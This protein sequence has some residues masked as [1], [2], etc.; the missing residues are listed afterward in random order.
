[1][2]K[3]V[4][5]IM[6][7]GIG[8]RYGGGI[9]QLAKVGPAGEIIMDYS[10]YDA[11]RAGFEKV[12]FVIRRDIEKDFKEIIGDRISREMEVAY[13]YQDADD[14]PAPF[15]RPAGRT[16][17]WGTGH[18]ILACRELIDA[19]F[20]VINADDYYGYEAFR[21]IYQFLENVPETGE[22]HYHF[23]MAGF[24][25]GNTLSD[26]GTVT[27][28]ICQVSAD[29]G[30]MG[31]QETKEIAKNADGTIRGV[32]AG[33]PC[34][35]WEDDLVSMNFWG[36][37][38]DFIGELQKRFVAF[39]ENIPEGDLKAE[40]L[41][42]IIVDDMLKEGVATVDVLPTNDSWF[43]LTYA[44]DRDSVAGRLKELAEDGTYPNPLFP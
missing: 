26:N 33:K 31:V 40:Y 43:G 2:K 19:P 16:K 34:S 24:V 32:Y 28:G 8:S 44:E 5:V 18:A 7:A 9:K 3:P 14:L 12:I 4:L 10:I 38:P 30:L 22:G 15:T 39:L 42:P 37:T 35:P 36:Y 23:A 6:A 13:A 29:G 27:R 11:K 41:L 21:K 1:M 17:P 25:L 20:A